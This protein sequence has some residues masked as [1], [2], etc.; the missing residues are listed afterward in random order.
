MKNLKTAHLTLNIVMELNTA[1]MPGTQTSPNENGMQVPSTITAVVKGSGDQSTPNKQTRMNLTLNIVGTSIQ[2]SEVTTTDMSYI[3]TPHSPWYSVDQATNGQLSNSLGGS[4]STLPTWQNIDENN[5][6]VLVEHSKFIDHGDE[7]VNELSLRHLT[8]NMDKAAFEHL[9]LSDS[10]NL[11]TMQDFSASADVYIDE[12]QFYIHRTELNVSY[13]T[14]TNGTSAKTKLDSTTDL[15][16]FN[17]PVTI[18]IPEN[19]TPL[20]DPNQLLSN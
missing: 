20:T 9:F 1:N 3:K 6:L 4:F 12:T 19:A 5:F 14:N 10:Q 11:N 15:S 13:T 2:M 17:R 16:N 8:V 7:N 18:T